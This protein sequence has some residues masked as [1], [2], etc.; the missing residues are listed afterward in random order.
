[1]QVLGDERSR[2]MACVY[3]A[4]PLVAELFYRKARR[5][6]DRRQQSHALCNGLF[7]NVES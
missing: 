1:M 4:D 2:E 6:H 5:H 7:C 3:E